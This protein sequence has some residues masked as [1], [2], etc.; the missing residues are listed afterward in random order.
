[1]TWNDI[2][3]RKLAIF[4]LQILL[5]SDG[6]LHFDEIVSAIYNRKQFTEMENT[7]DN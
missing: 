7:D 4:T 2:I 5:Q 3:L 1:M 6:V